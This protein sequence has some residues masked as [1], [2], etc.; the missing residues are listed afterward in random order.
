LANLVVTGL[1]DLSHLEL[2]WESTELC[3][4]F[5][6]IESPSITLPYKFEISQ[7]AVKL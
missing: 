2:K 7:V 3:S 1:A 4:P 6:V 5:L